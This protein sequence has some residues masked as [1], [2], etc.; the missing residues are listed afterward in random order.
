MAMKAAG[1]TL[2]LQSDSICDCSGKG[3]LPAPREP[4]QHH[5]TA[6]R[7][8]AGAATTSPHHQSASPESHMLRIMTG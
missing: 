7:I 1:L 5:H 8:H 4:A 2:W 3:G 6:V